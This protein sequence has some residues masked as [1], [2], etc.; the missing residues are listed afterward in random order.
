[1]PLNL[2]SHNV[3]GFD[4][5]KDF[6]RDTISSLPLSIYG[7]Q[8]HW[9]RPSSKHHPGVNGLKTIHS[10]LDGWGTSAMQASMEKRIL[11]GRPFGGTGFVWT[12]SLS[13][14]IKPRNVYKHDRVTVLEVSSNVGTILIINVYMPFF[15]NRNLE[16]Q[17]DLYSDTIGFIDSVINDNPHSSIVLLGDMNCNFYKRDNIFSNI[18]NTFIDQRDLCCT[19]DLM[20]TF[21]RDTTYTRFNLKQ[22]SFS[23]LDYI[24][25]SRNVVIH[26]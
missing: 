21:S 25:V 7:L 22:G 6:V 2:L 12:K 14:S 19:F 26:K 24:Y 11:S 23:L 8:E 20:P 15:D 4:R 18:L 1:M 9:L 16:S 17:T 3:N 5:N 13:S 10:D